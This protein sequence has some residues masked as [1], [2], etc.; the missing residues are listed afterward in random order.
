MISTLGWAN[1]IIYFVNGKNLVD[2]DLLDA[3]N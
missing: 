3:Y 1:K 2:I